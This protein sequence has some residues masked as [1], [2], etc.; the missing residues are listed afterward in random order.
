VLF[1]VIDWE[2][3]NKKIWLN[4]II[5]FYYLQRKEKR[6]NGYPSYMKTSLVTIQI[7]QISTHKLIEEKFCGDLN[8]LD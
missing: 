5:L 7:F 2:Y 6:Q 3:L 1:N 4:K 8:S